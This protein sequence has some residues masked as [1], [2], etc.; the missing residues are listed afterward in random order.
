[1]DNTYIYTSIMSDH[2][3]YGDAEREITDLCKWY[4]EARNCAKTECT[5][6]EVLKLRLDALKSVFEYKKT[7]IV[8]GKSGLSPV[9]LTR[10]TGGGFSLG[11]PLPT[12]SLSF[13]GGA[14]GGFGAPASG[15]L[16]FGSLDGLHA[17]HAVPAIVSKWDKRRPS[18][19]VENVPPPKRHRT[20][21]DG[22]TCERCDKVFKSTV[23]LKKHTKNNV[24]LKKKAI[25]MN[26]VW[27]YLSEKCDEESV[28]VYR[29]GDDRPDVVSVETYLTSLILVLQKLTSTLSVD[30]AWNTFKVNLD[31][32]NKIASKSKKSF[33][34][35]FDGDTKAPPGINDEQ[36]SQMSAS[37]IFVQAVDPGYSYS[38]S[39]SD[40]SS[41]SSSESESESESATE[42]ETLTVRDFLTKKKVDLKKLYGL[43][44]Y[45]RGKLPEDDVARNLVCVRVPKKAALYSCE[46]LEKHWTEARN[47]IQK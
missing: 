4:A 2:P 15:G 40:S 41:E 42:P 5:D 9:P 14:A 26:A 37:G 8:Y 12:D 29:F 36:S 28:K 17:P 46:F 44:V 16:S 18:D 25:D 43:S 38:S 19:L 30:N 22:G 45:Y 47:T 39:S 1:M 3:K 6:D 20:N 34:F 35:F 31:A 11:P 10:S 24:C 7:E 33:C 27:T 13:G 32:I 21:D 23:G